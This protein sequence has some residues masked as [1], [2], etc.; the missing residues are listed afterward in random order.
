M[1][2]T[3]AQ[4]LEA[5]LKLQSIDSQLDELKKIRGDLPEEVRDLE[6]DIA[7]FETRIGKFNA[8]I[9]VLEEE[10][11]RNKAIKKD[12]EKLITR[13]KDQQ[14]NVR[15]NRE[16]DAISKE[17][18]LQTLE[19]ELADKK[20]NEASFKIR[21]KQEE[22]KATQSALDERKE[23]L[24]AKM[25]E[26]NQI[27]SESRDEEKALLKDRDDQATHIEERLLKS[28]NKIRENA[29]NGLAVVVVKRGACGGC[30]NV[31]PPQR[32]ADIR[33]KKKII[34]CEHC[35]RVFADVEGVP[36]PVSSRR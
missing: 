31:V 34:V 35:G 8:D 10:I 17:V 22:I 15:N 4:K 1:E 33:D 25:Q 21:N 3:I 28:Y 14:M 18:E 20:I 24:K 7:G 16:F 11:D 29:L 9:Q 12:S 19:I 36:E 32:Q 23:D 5:L 30:F 27:T 13:Y 2:L 26:L 6:D